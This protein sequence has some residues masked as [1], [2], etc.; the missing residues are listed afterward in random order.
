[1][2]KQTVNVTIGGSLQLDATVTPNDAS[3]K[4]ISWSTSDDS[5]ATVDSSGLVTPQSIGGPVTITATSNADNSISDSYAIVITAKSLTSLSYLPVDMIG[6]V[7]TLVNPLRPV[8]QPVG[9][10]GTYSVNP[11]L[12]EG[13]TIDENDGVI[14]GIPNAVMA[15]NTY[16]VTFAGSGDYAGNS[17]HSDITITVNA[18]VINEIYYASIQGT[19]DIE[20]INSPTIIPTDALGTFAVIGD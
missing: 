17:T 14:R 4:T 13:L 8:V 15:E 11:Q 9:A 5:V 20:L 18:A 3:D 1:M 12:P 19:K 7:G 16:R 10:T 2:T 6:D